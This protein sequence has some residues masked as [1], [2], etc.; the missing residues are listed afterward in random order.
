MV[1]LTQKNFD[2]FCEALNHRMTKIETN[3]KWMSRIGYYMA[4]LLTT[5]VIKFLFFN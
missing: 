5:I 1:T 4:T 2:I 3:V